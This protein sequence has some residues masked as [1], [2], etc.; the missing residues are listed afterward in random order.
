MT[1]LPFHKWDRIGT[2]VGGATLTGFSK[3]I[4]GETTDTPEAPRRKRGHLPYA[5]FI[6]DSGRFGATQYHW[7]RPEVLPSYQLYA[8]D[9]VRHDSDDSEPFILE[10]VAVVD[11]RVHLR[12]LAPGGERV[13]LSNPADAELIRIRTA[14]HARD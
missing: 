11:H 3:T 13:F 4:K 2:A 10:S 5:H 12:W 6:T 8:G 7:L 14:R 1:E 9:L